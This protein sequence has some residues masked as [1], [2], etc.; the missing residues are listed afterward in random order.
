MW[1]AGQ[2]MAEL[3][4]EDAEEANAVGV[5][6][7]EYGDVP[8][9]V[10]VEVAVPAPSATPVGGLLG[11][12]RFHGAIEV[13]EHGVGALLWMDAEIKVLAVEDL[14]FGGFHFL[15]HVSQGVRHVNAALVV[16]AGF[17]SHVGRSP[18]PPEPES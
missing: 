2:T 15:Q 8:S 1:L 11:L 5:V 3:N 9:T 13:L 17:S 16:A 7:I 10:R 4:N 6:E 18:P 14:H 12:H